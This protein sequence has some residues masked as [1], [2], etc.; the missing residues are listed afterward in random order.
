MNIGGTKVFPDDVAFE[1]QIIEEDDVPMVK[2][3]HI[4]LREEFAD[5]VYNGR[6]NFEIRINDRGYQAGDF[7]Q[8]TV[9]DQYNHPCMEHPLN[10]CLYEI[11]YVLNGFGLQDGYVVFGIRRHK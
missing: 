1:T 9:I 6:K 8:F 2:T 4:K 5:D 7:V 11:T 10:N 3:H